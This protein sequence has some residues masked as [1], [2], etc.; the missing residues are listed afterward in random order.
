MQG[1]Q[2]ELWQEFCALAAE[3]R[4]PKKLLELVKEINRLLEEEQR[5]MNQ[6][7]AP[8]AAGAEQV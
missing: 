7:K 6:Q 1:E 5:L 3:E 8:A 4:D 2:R